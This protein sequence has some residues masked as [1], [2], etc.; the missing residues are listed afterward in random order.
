MRGRSRIPYEGPQVHL[1]LDDSP[2]AVP[3]CGKA[4]DSAKSVSK[5]DFF[6]TRSADRCHECEIRFTRQERV[7][8]LAEVIRQGE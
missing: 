4:K 8:A 3:V 6:R 7:R 1:S 2:G 5:S